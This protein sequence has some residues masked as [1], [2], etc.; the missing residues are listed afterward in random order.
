MKT[1]ILAGGLGLR[2]RS[3]VSDRPKVMAEVAGKA[4]L[5]RQLKLLKS[6]GLVDILICVGYGKEMI[7]DYFED[8]SKL[9][10]NIAYSIEHDLLG[11]GGA[12]KNAESLLNKTFL[13]VNGDTYLELDYEKFVRFH[14][15][16][17]ALVTVALVEVE[18]SLR[19]GH[20]E[21]THENQVVAFK[22]KQ[23]I[24]FPKSDLVNAGVYSMN[25]QLLKHI[26]DNKGISLE[27]EIFPKLIEA[28]F[29][30]FG[31][32]TAGFFVD[33]GIPE[34]LR[35]AQAFFQYSGGKNASKK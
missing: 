27:R 2:L 10:M 21:V 11:T 5:E 20:V 8:G 18:D 30:I 17:K 33:I 23:S 6:F 35:R 13:V 14:R 3:V 7:L 31:Y 1:V 32:K 19:Y 9:N 22:E 15:S 4:F 34:D 29:P 26:P 16:N 28:G 12:I 25:R 24:A